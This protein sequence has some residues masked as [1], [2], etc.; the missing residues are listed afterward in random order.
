MSKQPSVQEASPSPPPLPPGP[1]PTASTSAAGESGGQPVDVPI[2]SLGEDEDD[3]D[4]A[5]GPDDEVEEKDDDEEEEWDPAEERL[6][7]QGGAKDKGKGKA[8]DQSTADQPWQAVWAAEQ[9]GKLHSPDV[10]TGTPLTAQRGTFGTPK[11][12]K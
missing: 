6:P 8:E 10:S 3:S 4:A 9:N 11:Q 12:A 5:S 2:N 1:V 7:G